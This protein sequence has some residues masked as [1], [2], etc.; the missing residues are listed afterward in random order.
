METRS[1]YMNGPRNPTSSDT[2]LFR[3]AR[4]SNVRIQTR[5]QELP[6]QGETILNEDPVIRG[7]RRAEEMASVLDR[8][9]RAIP[10]RSGGCILK[11]GEESRIKKVQGIGLVIVKG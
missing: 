9:V 4:N 5:P 11:H 1:R 6:I 7:N 2:D 8:S 10:R 3:R